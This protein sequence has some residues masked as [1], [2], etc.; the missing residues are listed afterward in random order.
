MLALPLTY[1][2]AFTP[3]ADTASCSQQG[4]RLKLPT[5]RDKINGRNGGNEVC[6]DTRQQLLR[7]LKR[8]APSSVREFSE[9]L[10][11][12]ENTVRHHLGSFERDGLVETA[13][14]RDGVGRPA[15]R[16]SLT[17]KAEGMF[18]KHYDELLELV[19]GQAEAEDL[20]EPLLEGVAQQLQ[21]QLSP[22]LR[23]LKGEAR[24][25]A[26]VEHLDYGG[27]LSTLEEIEG[28]WELRA[29][30]CFYHA[31]GCKF[32]AVCDVTPRIITL[33]TGLPAERLFCQ[34]DG[35][36]AC[37]FSVDREAG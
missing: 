23:G 20:L 7:H 13:V 33:T 32:E 26:L 30:N 27:M 5:L 4:F 3:S 8:H 15:K 9:A 2:T 35:K 12:S 28:G 14:A 11:V 36:R 17:H 25:K 31:V 18:P 22:T 6:V 24:F 10:A 29:F 37:H 16:Y 34:R 19:L 21:R 1:V